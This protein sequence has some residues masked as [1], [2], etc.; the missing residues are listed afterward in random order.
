MRITVAAGLTLLSFILTAWLQAQDQLS[1]LDLQL[2]G[3][4]VPPLPLGPCE[5]QTTS[6]CNWEPDCSPEQGPYQYCYGLFFFFDKCMNTEG[7]CDGYDPTTLCGDL[8]E[9]SGH[10]QNP[11]TQEWHCTNCVTVGSCHAPG[12]DI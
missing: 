4:Q 9:C 8:R 3:G 7:E 10:I 12:C 6:P 11:N 5:E 1:S 2:V